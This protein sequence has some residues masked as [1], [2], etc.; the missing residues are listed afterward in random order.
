[1]RTTRLLVLGFVALVAP[2]ARSGAQTCQGMAA[3]QD[4]RWRAGVDDQAS[5][6]FNGVRGTLEFGLPQSIYGGID[7]SGLNVS[8]PGRATSGGAGAN[9]GYQIRIGDSPFQFCPAASWAWS[10]GDPDQT[11]QGALGASIGYSLKVS[12]WFAV[13]PAAGAWLIATRSWPTSH[14]LEVMDPA[15]G[16]SAVTSPGDNGT[17]GQA[18]VT[19]GLV[20]WKSL[21][22]NPGLIIPSQGGAKPVYTLGVSM[23]WSKPVS[24]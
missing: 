9:L 14:V 7:F 1:M 17:S 18:F 15:R 11:E 13:V 16:P 4:G 19:V 3:F 23:N 10:T 6:E 24:R 2:L 21:T 8:H 5:G 20:F 12:N 22:I